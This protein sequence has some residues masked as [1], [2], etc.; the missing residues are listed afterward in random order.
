MFN[1]DWY[2][3]TPVHVDFILEIRLSQEVW[4]KVVKLS[5]IRG[6]SYSWVV[7]YALF[8]FIK[9][10]NIQNFSGI[11]IFPPLDWRLPSRRYERLNERVKMERPNAHLKHRHR[12]CL[13]GEDELFIRLAAARL[14]CT[15]T[16]LV[17]LALEIYLDQ[18]LLQASRRPQKRRSLRNRGCDS[19]WY[20]L[21]IKLY[22]D[23]EFPAYRPR[24]QYFSFIRFDKFDYF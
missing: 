16:H 17:R 7:R 22:A 6:T 24:K 8:R 13:Y 5:R 9:R 2:Q 21:G 12:L 4:H 14:R 23:V 20:W 19:F 15:M 18:V 1:R 10:K 3:K 11:T